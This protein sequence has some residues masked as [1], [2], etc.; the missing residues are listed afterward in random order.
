MTA[1]IPAAQQDLILKNNLDI[2][3][4]NFNDPV[5]KVSINSIPKFTGAQ[6][7]AY[8]II[9]Q[10]RL[11][12]ET[13]RWPTGLVG[14]PEA[15]PHYTEGVIHTLG[16]WNGHTNWLCTQVPQ[17]AGLV[18]AGAGGAGIGQTPIQAQIITGNAL[19]DGV[20]VIP[21][22]VVTH[23]ALDAAQTT[24]SIIRIRARD[25]AT[26]MGTTTNINEPINDCLRS[27]KII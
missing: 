24:R 9:Q 16:N 19:L 15:G 3:A 26:G 17:K 13:N 6:E 23:G 5:G 1:S 27:K 7:D 18:A 12:A 22:A 11:I 25:N 8:E 14:T 21:G 4:K 20:E 2:Q 10:I